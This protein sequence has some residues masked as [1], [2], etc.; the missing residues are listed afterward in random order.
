MSNRHEALQ[1]A[2][3]PN[4]WHEWKLIITLL[5]EWKSTKVSW[6]LSQNSFDCVVE[7]VVV[8]CAII[9]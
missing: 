9:D 7:A 6:W 2:M 1:R 4:T 5:P 3:Q 8:V